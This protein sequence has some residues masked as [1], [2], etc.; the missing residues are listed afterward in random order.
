MLETLNSERF[1]DKAP[2]EVYA[3]LLDEKRYLCSPRTMY[4]IL[5]GAGEVRER[6]DQL[7]HPDYKKP[8]LLATA[9][10]QVWSWD[11]TKLLGPAK[12]TYYYLYVILDIYSRY[13]VGWMV[14]HAESKALAKK[15]I[16]ETFAKQAIVP[17]QLTIHA[18]RGSSMISKPVA[19]LMADLGVTKSHSRPHVS[20]DNPFSESQFK[21]LKY[22]PGFPDRFGSPED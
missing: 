14:A 19:F 4:R 7:R 20:N 6:R 12:W 1:A 3:T 11:I 21:T 22:R 8:E 17:G 15:L 10:N 2:T 16:A 9:P 13:V 18:D 5:A